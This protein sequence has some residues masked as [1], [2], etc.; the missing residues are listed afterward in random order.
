MNPDKLK[1]LIL[2][3]AS[4]FAVTGFCISFLY[5]ESVYALN[6]RIVH[7]L[8]HTFTSTAFKTFMNIVSNIFNPTVCAGY[9]LILYVMTARKLEVIAFLLWFLFLSWTI[10]I[11]KQLFQYLKDNTDNQGHFG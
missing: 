9:I 6:Q 5:Y 1:L 11:L 3:V 4:L 8:Q 2:L 7:S 10:S